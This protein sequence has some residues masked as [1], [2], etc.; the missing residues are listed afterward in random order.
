MKTKIGILSA[1]ALMMFI[2][3][4]AAML[5][6]GV[7]SPLGVQGAHL[8]TSDNGQGAGLQQG[9]MVTNVTVT[10]SPNE[11]GATA[12]YTVKFVTGEV[13]QANVDTIVFD[14][15][16]SGGVPS[17]ISASDV[18][19]SASVV[20]GGGQ[21]NQFVTPSLDPSHES[22]SAGRD[23]YTIDVPDM[24]ATVSPRIQ[25]ID[26]DATVTVIFPIGAGFTNPTESGSYDFTISTS[27]ETTGVMATFTTPLTL[28]ISD[29]AD[30]R[31]TP[32]TVWGK[33]F[34][35]GTVATTYLDRSRDANGNIV[36]VPD[37]LRTP[38]IDVDLLFTHVGSDD[39]FTETYNVTV[40]PF[41]VEGPNQINVIDSEDPP[42]YYNGMGGQTPVTFTIAPLLSIP[43]SLV[44][45]GNE[46]ELTL[47][48][49]PATDRVMDHV[50]ADSQGVDQVI[51]SSVTI[52]GIPQQITS[53]DGQVGSDNEHTFRILVGTAVQT[54]VQQ[55][56]V[57]TYTSGQ[58][59][60]DV[61]AGASDTGNIVIQDEIPLGDT[62]P[63]PNSAAGDRAALVALFNATDGVNWTN[64]TNWLTDAP[65]DEWYGVSVGGLPRRVTGL[66]L[67][68]NH[69]SGQMPAELGNLTSLTRLNLIGNQLS[70][71]IPEE[72]GSLTNLWYLN[73]SE[74]RFSG[75]ITAELGGLSSLRELYLYENQLTGMIPAQLGRLA[76]LEYLD[77]ARN[78]LN[79]TIPAQ[80][81]SL[82]NLEYLDLGRNQL[83]GPVPSD[84]GRLTNLGVLSLGTNRL[85]GTI[86][87]Q[88]GSPTNLTHLSLNHNQLSGQIPEELGNLTNLTGLFLNGNQLTG[89]IPEELGN[90]TDLQ[91]LD[92]RNNQLA[93][94]IPAELGNLTNLQALDLSINQLSEQIP[95]DLGDL[96][97]LNKLSLNSNRLSGEIPEELGNLTNLESVYLSKNQLIGCIPRSLKRVTNNDLAGLGL[98]FCDMFGPGSVVGDRDAL[99]ALYNATDGASW[100]NNSGWLTDVPM[101]QWHGVETANTGRV[102]GLILEANQLSG[103]IPDGLGALTNLATLNLGS[104]RLRGEIPAGLGNLTNLTELHVSFNQLS[105]TIPA[106]L[107]NLTN[108][109]SLQLVGNLL[110]GGIPAGLGNLTNLT[111]L[112]LWSNRL[113]GEIPVELGSLT[114]LTKLDLSQNPISG[115]IPV[116]LGNLTNLRSLRFKGNQLSGEIPPELSNLTSLEA[117]FLSHN[118]LTG[119]IPE[120]LGSLSNLAGLFLNHNQ[121]G[122]DIPGELGGLTNL[123]GLYLHN[124]QLGGE[125]P[126]DLGSLANL[127]GMHLND[128][129]LIGQIP[130][131][132]GNLSN[133]T[134]LLLGHNQLT[135]RIPV[136]LGNLTNLVSLGLNDNKLSGDVPLELRNLSNLGSVYLSNNQLTGCVPARLRGVPHNDFTELGLPFCEMPGPGSVAGD[137]AVLVALYDATD[138]ANWGRGNSGWL[139]S[140]P[141]FQ[142]FGV[143]TD[144]EGR[145]SALHLQSNLLNGEI[146]SELG[147]LTNLTELDLSENYELVG[148][149][150]AELGNLTNL[151]K[152][153]LYGNR[154]SGEIPAELGNLTN[155]TRFLLGGNQLTGEI[156][157][158]LGSLTN[159]IHLQLGSNQLSGEIPE[160][161]G[162]LTNL[163]DLELSPNRLTG[164]IPAGLRSAAN[165]DLAD[166]GIPFCDMLNGSPVSV[167]RF[168]PADAPVRIDSSITLEATFSEPVSGFTLDDVSVANGAASSFSG[169]GAVYTFDV[170]PN[171]IGEVT[172]DIAA[173]AAEDA[174]GKGNVEAHLPIGI[175]YDDDGNGTINRP[176]VIGAVD[177]Y[178]DGLI[179]REQVIAVIVLYFSS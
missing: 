141:I 150:P 4:I 11:P 124:N 15:N 58:M 144:A 94:K 78:Q 61:P 27:K 131:D 74:N 29:T 3:G 85:S 12:Q 51:Q 140:A 91:T 111:E 72:L 14:I 28:H 105:G 69:L 30:H 37:G 26:A 83:T 179:T 73:L 127:T 42:N 2:G 33:G 34:K 7:I 138:G 110:S 109:K 98:H 40:P 165:S 20:T 142:W 93:G 104:N 157:S 47:V 129:Q 63:E 161:L 121:L 49:W 86:P 159:L 64:T 19:M 99:V 174:E 145:V 79:G 68:R 154:L 113:S 88:L 128:N 167:I 134:N 36:N 81:G 52:A 66:Y 92:L 137:R 43:T 132:L 122:G 169:S 168:M 176:E 62:P 65:L 103:E 55:L 16:S 59:M 130:T 106:G 18:F 70:G 156:P 101:S 178:F 177:D 39:T 80:L 148:E 38:G 45:L 13:L 60:S 5:A 31:D 54:G 89:E 135:G 17:S 153:Y 115:E 123:T 158:Q 32:I 102:T 120:E 35:N 50:T 147:N 171:A 97:N 90:S 67:G 146:P 143:T 164:C 152:L 117:L 77:L 25:S 125:I 76:N 100:A 107:G 149:I 151:T 173:S 116:E 133:L 126:A 53:G 8:P 6:V 95:A 9:G 160:E 96:T 23:I 162:N 41:A 172:V 87:T 48:D 136:E 82:A 21:A 10:S 170:T 163:T 112:E 57:K 22:G 155:L 24:D 44:T 71:T 84:L 75:E 56:K 46:V 139:T 1:L 108:L 118:Q 166:L 114:N 119:R 175:P